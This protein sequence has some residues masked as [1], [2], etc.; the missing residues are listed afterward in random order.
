MWHLYVGGGPALNIFRSSND[1]RPEGGFSGLAG[2]AHR[3]G[4]FAEA[5]VGALKSPSF[6]FGV[7]YTFHP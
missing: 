3:S 6:K 2:I 1:T 4:L 5:K 7:G